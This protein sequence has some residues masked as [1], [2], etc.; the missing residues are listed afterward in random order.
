MLG[1]LVVA[2]LH[3][4]P[5]FARE[6]L[7]QLH[8]PCSVFLRSPVVTQRGPRLGHRGA[9]LRISR[10][11]RHSLRQGITREHELL[12][13]QVADSLHTVARLPGSSPNAP[14]RFRR[15]GLRFLD[16]KAL[17]KLITEIRHELQDTVA[18]A[19][20]RD[21]GHGFSRGGVLHVQHDSQLP[22]LPGTA[23]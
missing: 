14:V 6:S 4:Q 17:A 19:R 18:R 5:V 2:A 7:R 11:G 12:T 3:Q 23:R 1:H 10:I 15:R 13:V 20:C 8:C 9:D 21:R 16:P 22:S